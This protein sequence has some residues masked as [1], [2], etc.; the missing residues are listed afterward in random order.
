MGVTLVY[1]LLLLF[2]YSS[3]TS[4]STLLAVQADGQA[5][6]HKTQPQTVLPY[7]IL[8]PKGGSSERAASNTEGFGSAW[9]KTISTCY[10]KEILVLCFWVAESVFSLLKGV[11]LIKK[12]YCVVVTLFVLRGIL[13]GLHDG[14]N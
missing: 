12:I 13:N 11:H 1:R 4:L 2:S 9:L 3:Q 5:H 6:S 8:R 10:L 14:D 7:S